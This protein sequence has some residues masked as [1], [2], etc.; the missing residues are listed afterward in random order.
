MTT[1]DLLADPD[2]LKRAQDEFKRTK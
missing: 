1:L 2:L